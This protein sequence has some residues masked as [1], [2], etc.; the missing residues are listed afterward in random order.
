[1]QEGGNTIF[2]RIIRRESPAEIIYEDDNALAFYDINPQAPVHILV[3]P[4]KAIPSLEEIDE[5]ESYLLGHLLLVARKV[6][7][8]VGI[9]SSGYRLVINN[10]EDGMQTVHHLHIHLLGKRKMGWPPG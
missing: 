4:K 2:G 5:S 8:D 9:D 10:G 7:R 6:A 1:M 3:V